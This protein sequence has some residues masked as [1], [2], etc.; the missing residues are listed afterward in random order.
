MR[1]IR[2]RYFINWTTIFEWRVARCG[3][4]NGHKNGSTCLKE[5]EL[6]AQDLLTILG[7]MIMNIII[8][9]TYTTI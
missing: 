3:S 8:G 7:S 9:W 5:I 2:G 4:K 6:C 1:A